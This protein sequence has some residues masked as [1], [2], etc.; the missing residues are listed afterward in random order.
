MEKNDKQIQKFIDE[1]RSDP[2]N[3]LPP[4]WEKMLRDYQDELAARPKKTHF[5]PP[6]LESPQLSRHSM[7]WRMGRGEDY[8][9]EFL[10]WFRRMSTED[11]QDYVKDYPEESGWVGFY[12]AIDK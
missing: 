8:M 7:G 3:K 12:D 5:P 4:H 11:K 2:R 6:W 1:M 10:L 9:S